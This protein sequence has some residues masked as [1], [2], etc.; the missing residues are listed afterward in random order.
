MWGNLWLQLHQDKE[1]MTGRT[2]MKLCLYIVATLP[3]EPNGN[4]WNCRYCSVKHVLSI[5]SSF[6]AIDDSPNWPSIHIVLEDLTEFRYI[7]TEV[8][9]QKLPFE[10]ELEFVRLFLICRN[11]TDYVRLESLFYLGW[12]YTS[13]FW[14]LL[15][16][17]QCEVCIC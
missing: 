17:L 2:L 11:E 1:T 3:L 15:D 8:G 4:S 10:V 16:I 14:V 6:E 9:S 5:G 13:K 12:L 7:R